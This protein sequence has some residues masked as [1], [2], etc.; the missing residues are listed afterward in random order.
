MRPLPHPPEA[1]EHADSIEV[2]RGWIVKGELR[3]S[4]APCWEWREQP[5]EWGRLLAEA[6]G[7]MAD[8]I[9][10]ET[11]KERTEIYRMILESITQHLEK[12]PKDAGAQKYGLMDE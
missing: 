7:Q 1:E 10:S 5:A 4:I 11:G 3:V 9:S 8:A 12:L 6:A 2:L